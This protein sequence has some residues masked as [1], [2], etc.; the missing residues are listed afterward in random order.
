MKL[1]IRRVGHPEFGGFAVWGLVRNKWCQLSQE[2]T[3][4]FQAEEFLMKV[5][6]SQEEEILNLVCKVYNYSLD[7]LL[8]KF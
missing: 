5:K 8:S 7:S 3:Y 4:Y 1:E 6:Q 2:L